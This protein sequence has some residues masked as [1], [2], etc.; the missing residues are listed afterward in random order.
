MTEAERVSFEMVRFKIGTP[1]STPIS[2][3]GAHREDGGNRVVSEKR[4]ETAMIPRSVEY[5]YSIL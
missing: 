2:S 3:P 5:D 1:M 4:H